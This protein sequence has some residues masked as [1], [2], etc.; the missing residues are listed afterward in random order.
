[1]VELLNTVTPVTILIFYA[2]EVL[3]R[4]NTV[5]LGQIA[6]YENKSM[7]FYQV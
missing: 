6:K 3:I 2:Q 7:I 1:M 5:I 4:E